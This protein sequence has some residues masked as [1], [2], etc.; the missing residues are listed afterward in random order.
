MEIDCVIHSNKISIKIQVKKKKQNLVFEVEYFFFKKP[1]LCAVPR[2][3]I[4]PWWKPAPQELLASPVFYHSC[5]PAHWVV[6]CVWECCQRKLV[7]WVFVVFWGVFVF[8]CHC[9]TV[10]VY[11]CWDVVVLNWWLS[12]K[13]IPSSVSLTGSSHS[14][15][16]HSLH[17]CPDP[18]HYCLNVGN[19]WFRHQR[20]DKYCLLD[21][22]TKTVLFVWHHT[23]T[24]VHL[25]RTTALMYLFQPDKK[26]V[27]LLVW[28]FTSRPLPPVSVSSIFSSRSQ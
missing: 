19:A 23:W 15:Y 11:F 24:A 4:S 26:K 27:I 18:C 6:G 5:G 25:F 9:D 1:S 22:L 12:A 21:E 13:I 28:C 16:N 10:C 3:K 17:H 2:K 7:P 8:S 14:I 20:T